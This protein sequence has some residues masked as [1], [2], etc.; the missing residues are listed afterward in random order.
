MI[1]VIS[2]VAFSGTGKTTFL[3]KLI[4][5]IKEYGLRVAVVKHDAHEFEIDKEGKDSYRIT[6]A[7]ASITGLVSKSKSVIIENRPTSIEEVFDKITDV[8]LILTEGFKT[9]NWPKIMLHRQATGKDLP[10][11]PE[12]CIAVVSDV[13]IEDAAVQFDLDDVSGV[14]E[15]IVHY[16]KKR[17]NDKRKNMLYNVPFLQDLDSSTLDGL[18]KEGS[19]EVFKKG[20]ILLQAR[21]MSEAVFIQL[22][23]KSALYNLTVSGERK[24][25]FIFGEGILL[26]DHVMTNHA[27]SSYCETIEKSKV[28]VISKKLFFKWMQKDFNLT[29]AVLNMQEWKMWRMGHQ[30]KNTNGSIYLERKL[31]A[32]LWKLGR[33]FGVKTEL[34]VE[35]D[36][37][38]SITFLSDMLGCPRETTSRICRNL[39]EKGL[40]DINKKRI[41]ILDPE[42]LSMYYKI[43][44]KK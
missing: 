26:N 22:T 27:P 19:V 40:I 36:V 32:K 44:H 17:Y 13:V 1:P 16:V 21:S 7:G 30:L 28:F 39:Q 14:A 37:N 18:W 9:G 25:I 24:V 29:T 34:G 31:A 10:L 38:L 8:D 41:T 35:I 12:D 11:S 6:K 5:Q 3:E 42:R 33:D 4:P 2:I 43:G 15:Y 23:G 20:T